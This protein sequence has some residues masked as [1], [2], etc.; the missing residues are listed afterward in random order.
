LDFLDSV[1]KNTQI[2][3]F[4]KIYPMGAKLF[5]ADKQMD[6]Q[7]DRQTEGERER[8]T[9]RQTDRHDE[10]NASFSQFNERA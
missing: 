3:N 2:P 4:M 7:T 8:E 1:S 9:D 10:A 5:H 6:G